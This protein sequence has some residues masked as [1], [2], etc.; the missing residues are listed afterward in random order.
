MANTKTAEVREQKIGEAHIESMKKT[1]RSINLFPFTHL[2]G[3]SIQELDELIAEC[4]VE[5]TDPKLK[6]YIPM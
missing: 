4:C 6:A 1:M 5:A 2:L 3:K